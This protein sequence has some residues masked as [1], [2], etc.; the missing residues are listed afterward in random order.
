MSSSGMRGRASALDSQMFL[1]DLEELIRFGRIL[2]HRPKSLGGRTVA[3][4]LAESWLRVRTRDGRVQ[5][6]T[7]N[8]VQQA[9]ELRRGQRNIVLK[10]RQLGLT[11]WVAARFF[12]RTIT[13]PGTLTLQVAHTQEA[14]EAIFRIVHRFVAHL[15]EE[16]RNGPLMTSHASVRQLVFP[17][18]DSQYLVVS[19]AD[20]NAGRGLTAQNLHCSELARWPGDPCETL[21]GLRAALA[22]EGELVLESTPDGVGGG[23]HDEWQRAEETGMVRHFFPWWMEARY[24][25]AAVDTAALTTDERNLM[26]REGLDLEQIGFRRQVRANFRGLARQEYAED[27]ESCFR[28]SGACVFELEAIETRLAELSPPVETRQNGELAIWLPPMAGK[29][30]V[31]AVDPAGG[32]SEGD[33]SAAQVVE[34]ETGLQCAEYAGH[35]SGLN[36]AQLTT[37]LAKEYNEAELVVERNNHGSSVLALASIVCCYRRIYEQAGK[38]GWLTDTVS[39]PAALSRLGAMLVERPECFLSPRLL[40]ECRSFV[41]LP[42]GRTGA[43]AGTHDDRVMAMAIALAVR[44][45]LLTMRGGRLT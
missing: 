23:F 5:P 6:L 45:E 41:R 15:P 32:G 30:Y 25:A 10:A 9:F 11:T 27:A 18:L 12:L 35:M 2:D 24:R 36:L 21:A 20:R 7:P 17:S 43:R 37:E 28:T 19:A 14:A 38:A 26:E 39:C 1:S 22:P 29:R 16:L 31:V 3:M 8:A 33:Y 42:N 13:Q 4:A 34:L 44:E 40:A